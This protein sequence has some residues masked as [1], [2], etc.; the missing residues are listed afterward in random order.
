MMDMS[1]HE[2]LFTDCE[3]LTEMY[4]SDAERLQIFIEQL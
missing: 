2:D 4:F 3:K 1:Q